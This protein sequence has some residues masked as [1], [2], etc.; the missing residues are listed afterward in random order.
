MLRVYGDRRSGNCLKVAY[1][2]DYLGIPYE[3]TDVDIMAGESRT[4]AFLA[5]N[6]EG[7][8]PLVELG[9]GRYLRQSDAILLHLGRGSA[10][11]PDDPWLLAQVYQWLFWEQYSHEANVAVCRFQRLYLGRSDA[12]LDPVR[13]RKG[14]EALDL[15]EQHLAARDWLVGEGLTVADIALVAYTRLADE[16]GFNL[17]GRP[18]V[19]QWIARV[20]TALGIEARVSAEA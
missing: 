19:R 13:V 14:N 12:E 20:E 15:M 18:R 1:I 8:V 16:G 7:Q 2:A 17:G 3:W 9:D 5:M 11:V 4:A 6:P 10:L